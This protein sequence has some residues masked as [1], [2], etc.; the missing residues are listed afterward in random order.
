MYKTIVFDLDGTLLNTITDLANAGNRLCAAHGW[1]THTEDEYRYFVGNGIPKLVERMLPESART[2]QILAAALA[3]YEADYGAHMRDATAPYPGMPA[4]L[5]DLKAAGLQ[6]AVFSNKEDTLAR[7]VV[8]DYFDATL[9]DVV[10]G[11][12]AGVPVKPAPEGTLA[13]LADL[14]ADPA[15]TLYVGDSNVDVATAKNA[16]LP[17]CGVLWGFRTRSE[18]LTAGADFLAENAA[19]LRTLILGK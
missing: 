6:L 8:A 5:A 12:R 7:G 18:L 9:F 19:A 11:A 10:R 15:H 3:E 4:L 13:L 1:P 2:P 14:H 17:C 16:A